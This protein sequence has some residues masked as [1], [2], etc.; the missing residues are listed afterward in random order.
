MGRVSISERQKPAR[1]WGEIMLQTACR[2]I[3]T[4]PPGVIQDQTDIVLKPRPIS[5]GCN[6]PT[7]RTSENPK[8]WKHQCPDLVLAD[9]HLGMKGAGISP[10]HTVRSMA[11]WDQLSSSSR[12][13]HLSI[14]PL[15]LIL[16][17]RTCGWLPGGNGQR[18]KA[19]RRRSARD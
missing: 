9:S 18:E 17:L 14:L 8:H 11:V 4:W 10:A 7:I 1:K 6:G 2:E 15:F 3:T 19:M 12:I 16:L 5:A 13:D